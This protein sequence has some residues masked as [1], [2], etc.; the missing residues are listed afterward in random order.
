MTGASPCQPSPHRILKI[1]PLKSKVQQTMHVQAP[2]S[3]QAEPQVSTSTILTPLQIK[4]VPMSKEAILETSAS[5]SPTLGST[6]QV[7]QLAGEA[8]EDGM[9]V[10]VNV[11][12]VQSVTPIAS[13]NVCVRSGCTN[14]AVQSNDWDYEYCSN[15]CVATH[16]SDE[17]MAWCA[18]RGPNSTTVT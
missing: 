5:E 10:Q 17:F 13:C 14:P 1:N 2:P 18:I 7:G 11:A 3:L 4:V 16:C 12:P 9:E 15:E 8:V 6:V